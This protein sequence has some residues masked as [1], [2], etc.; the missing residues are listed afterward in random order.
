MGYEDTSDTGGNFIATIKNVGTEVLYNWTIELVAPRPLVIAVSNQT[1]GAYR[2]Q[3]SDDSTSL[4]NNTLGHAKEHPIRPGGKYV[5]KIAYQVT[6]DSARWLDEKVVARAYVEE[7]IQDQ[8]ERPFRELTSF[9]TGA[10][11]ALRA[12]AKLHAAQ[13]RNSR[14]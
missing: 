8:K 1:Q 6:E 4:F 10:R 9:F 14:G 2:A 5:F 3:H 12:E 13:I 7:K 11:A